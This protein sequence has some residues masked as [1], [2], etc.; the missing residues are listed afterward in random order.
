MSNSWSGQTNQGSSS[1]IQSFLESIRAASAKDTPSTAE[2]GKPN[3]FAEFQQRKEIEKKRIAEF[4]NSRVTEWNQVFSAKEKAVEKRIEQI[5]LEL[6]QLAKQLKNIDVNLTKAIESPVE[7]A[8]DYHVTYLE[9]IKEEIHL[10]S[11]QASKTNSWLE[12]YNQR[13]RKMGTYWA[14]AKSKGTSYT[15]NN[16]R[17][18]ATSIG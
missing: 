7:E 12:L 13:S 15:Q 10:F 11:L 5:K 4:Q 8:G 2:I 18:V 1:K 14:Q 6:S 16:E 9:H 3:P 17:S